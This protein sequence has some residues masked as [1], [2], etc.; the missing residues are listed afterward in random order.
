M[1]VSHTDSA[2]NP[3]APLWIASNWPSKC[4]QMQLRL[5]QTLQG[6]FHTQPE[7]EPFSQILLWGLTAP[8]A[9]LCLLKGNRRRDCLYRM[10]VNLN[11]LSSNIHGAD[12]ASFRNCMTRLFRP[13]LARVADPIQ[14]ATEFQVRP[15]KIPVAID[16]LQRERSAF[17]KATTFQIGTAVHKCW[18][19]R[20]S[21]WVQPWHSRKSN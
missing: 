17:R 13:V 16:H 6:G 1:P 14:H 11:T 9:K 4:F 3:Q 12:C 7:P 2:R 10:S 8:N 18:V 19:L 15:R 20:S 21:N 5:P